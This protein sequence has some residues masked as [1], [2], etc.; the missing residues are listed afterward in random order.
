MSRAGMSWKDTTSRAT[1]C[2]VATVP[3]QSA[4]G[5]HAKLC[6]HSR[7]PKS[8]RPGELIVEVPASMFFFEKQDGVTP[9][10]G[11]VIRFRRFAEIQQVLR[12]AGSNAK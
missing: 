2:D 12:L 7:V 8:T 9:M 10:A 11:P 3:F 5:S 1:G 4:N 6:G